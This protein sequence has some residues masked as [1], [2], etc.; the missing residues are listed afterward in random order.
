[1]NAPLGAGALLCIA[2]SFPL[3]HGQSSL[4]FDRAFAQHLTPA[5][6]KQIYLACDLA[7]STTRLEMQEAMK[8]SVVSEELKQREFGGDFDRML[9]WWK[10]QRRKEEKRTAVRGSP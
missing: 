9:A 5:Q 1:M 8:C 3:A 6:L 4:I 10:T 7:S 2:L